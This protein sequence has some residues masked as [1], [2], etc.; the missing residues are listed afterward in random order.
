MTIRHTVTV[1]PEGDTYAALRQHRR[2]ERRLREAKLAGALA[3]SPDGRLKCEVPRCDFEFASKYGEAGRGYIQVHHLKPIGARLSA[4]ATSLDDLALVCPNCHAM[5]HVGG[6]LRALHEIVK[7]DEVKHGLLQPRRPV[8]GVQ[9]QRW[10]GRRAA[11]PCFVSHPS[12]S[13]A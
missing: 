11:E 4:E 12:Q 1:A 2:R 6:L 10:C 13:I 8:V 3:K 7:P 5:I 9:E